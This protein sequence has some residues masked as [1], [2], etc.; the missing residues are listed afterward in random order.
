MTKDEKGR[1]EKGPP[2][3]SE[4]AVHC[5]P[6]VVIQD[7]PATVFTGRAVL[8]LL[9]LR[10]VHVEYVVTPTLPCWTLVVAVFELRCWGVWPVGGSISHVV[11][12]RGGLL[13]RV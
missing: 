10:G 8:V 5:V 13:R 7:C 1:M 12:V 4:P 2:I 6:V 9:Q 3:G 11:V